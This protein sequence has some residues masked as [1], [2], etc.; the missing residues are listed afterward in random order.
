MTE[1]R[2]HADRVQAVPDPRAPLAPSG[3]EGPPASRAAVI[4]RGL[5]WTSSWSLKIGLIAVAAFVVGWLIEWGWYIIFPVLLALIFSTVLAPISHL[6][7]SRARFPAALAAA[8]AM[9]V[10]FA[11][12]AGAGFAI[13]PQVVDQAPTIA[14][15]VNAGLRQL[16]DWV[17]S[18]DFVT[19]DQVDQALDGLQEV[20]TGSA[21]SIA[22][23]VLVGVS[24]VSNALVTI[25]L[26]LVLTFFFLKDGPRFLPWVGRLAGPQAGDHLVEVGVRAWRTLGGFIRAQALV[27]LVDAVFIGGG[28]LLLGVPLAIPLAVL[29]FFAGFIPIVGAVTAGALAVLVGLVDGGLTTAL[30]VL[31]LILAVQQIESNV[32]QP[33][34]QSKSMQL[35]PA[36]VLLSVTLG[37]TLFGITGAFLAVPVVAVAAV[38]LRYLDEVVDAHVAHADTPP[39]VEGEADHASERVDYAE[40]PSRVDDAAGAEEAVVPDSSAEADADP[41][42]REPGSTSDDVTRSRRSD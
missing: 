7:R 17:Q 41:G 36:V 18:S 25:V 21:S 39:Y 2:D 31:A 3:H 19:A 10:F 24:A 15:Q 35:H 5:T 20:V 13:A 32:L 23:G 8:A 28:L 26:A 40:R 29:T 14:N 22:S 42:S 4:G 12:L 16:Q 33:W 37:A 34:L 11:V 6:L 1:P 30:L 38:V 9:V 27:S